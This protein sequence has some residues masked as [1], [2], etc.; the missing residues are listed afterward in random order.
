MDHPIK[1]AFEALMDGAGG[2]DRLFESVP[3]TIFWVKDLDHRFV[4]ANQ[5]AA[6]KAGQ[7]DVGQLLGKTDLDCYPPAIARKFVADDL[8]VEKT[9]QAIVNRA[10]MHILETGSLGWHC[11]TKVPLHGKDGTLI[12]VA[13]ISRKMDLSAPELSAYRHLANVLDFIGKHFDRTLSRRE[14]ARIAGVS[15]TEFGRRFKRL[16]GASPGEFIRNLRLKV[17]CTRLAESPDSV[18]KIAVETGFYD[19]SVFTRHFRQAMGLTPLQYRRKFAR[20]G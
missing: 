11:T 16:M 10:E 18:G 19:A 14:L 1:A 2:L 5:A 15:E 13:G 9:G 12:G 3:G 7:R 17:A 8:W 20:L 4:M 6:E